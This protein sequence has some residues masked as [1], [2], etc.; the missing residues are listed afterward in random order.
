MKALFSTLLTPFFLMSQMALAAPHPLTGS[1]IINK[2]SN[3][4]AFTQLGFSLD[5]IPENWNYTRST[6]STTPVLEIGNNDQT[7]LSFRLETVTAKT[8]LETYVRQHLRDYNQ[9]GFEVM[10]LQSH[11]KS[12]TPSVIVDLRQKNNS[13]RSRQVFFH[14]D[15]KLI[16]A[17]CADTQQRFDQTLNTCNRILGTFTWR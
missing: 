14:K 5:S 17:T 4:M 7:L 11:N 9:Y 16:I 10:G 1:S 13:S 6:E 3:S 8:K 15:D 12:A 2:A